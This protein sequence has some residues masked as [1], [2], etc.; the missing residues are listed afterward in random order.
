ML[1]ELRDLGAHLH[2]M[3]TDKMAFSVFS[4]NIFRFQ[5]RKKK[6]LPN[7]FDFP[8]KLLHLLLSIS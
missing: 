4:L 6:Q 3:L 7:L 8:R 2:N 1:N 5:I